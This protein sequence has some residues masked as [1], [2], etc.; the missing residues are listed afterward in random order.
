V[1]VA[2]VNRLAQAKYGVSY[3]CPDGGVYTHDPAT[4]EVL[5]SVYGNRQHPQQNATLSERASFARLLERLEEITATLRFEEEWLIATV[6][7]ARQ[8]EEKK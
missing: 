4:D 8:P 3:I 2:E 1:P 6:E 5:S 7:I